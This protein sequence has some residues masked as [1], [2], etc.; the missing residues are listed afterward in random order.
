MKRTNYN[1][2]TLEAAAIYEWDA[3]NNTLTVTITGLIKVVIEGAANLKEALEFYN[4]TK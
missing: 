2:Q 3:A 1:P 4:A